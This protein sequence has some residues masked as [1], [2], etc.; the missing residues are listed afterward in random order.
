MLV[1]ENPDRKKNFF[2]KK[3]GM[4]A[5]ATVDKELAQE[6]H[7]PLVKNSNKEGSM[8]G[9]RIIFEQL[10]SLRWDCYLL[11]DKMLNIKYLLCVVIF[12]PNMLGLNL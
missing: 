11:K 4:G 2:G 12:S 6:L 1:K 3:K 5:K 10:I 7:Q 9:L 8:Q